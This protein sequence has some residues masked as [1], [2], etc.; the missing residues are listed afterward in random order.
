MS[1]NNRLSRGTDCAAFEFP[2]VF[3]IN[4]ESCSAACLAEPN[5]IGIEV[6]NVDAWN[7]CVMVIEASVDDCP[8]G[9]FIFFPKT[10]ITSSN[11]ISKLLDVTFKEQTAEFASYWQSINFKLTFLLCSTK[12]KN[13]LLCSV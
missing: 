12:K 11:D 9:D 13:N 3:D 8:T 6:D 5:C 4:W 10:C 7:V 1:L 2:L